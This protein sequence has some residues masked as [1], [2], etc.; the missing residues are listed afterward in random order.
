MARAPNPCLGP[1]IR[2]GLQPGSPRVHPCVED[3]NNSA[4]S[5]VAG[6]LLQQRRQA[7][8]G[9]RS[10]PGH[11]ASGW[12]AR[13]LQQLT[14][15]WP[16]ARQAAPLAGPTSTMPVQARTAWLAQLGHLQKLRRLYLLLGHRPT[17]QVVNLRL[18]VGG[19]GE[20]PGVYKA[21]GN[22]SGVP[23]CWP[24]SRPRADLQGI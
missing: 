5:I 17:K 21:F 10:S 18:Q 14:L 20:G 4:S 3:G 12:A 11:R 1:A 16:S 8:S 2:R 9:E 13:L 7:T 15:A 24:A 19:E 6:V 23:R 22:S